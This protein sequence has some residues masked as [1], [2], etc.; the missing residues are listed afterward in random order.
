M[1][2]YQRVVHVVVVVVGQDL[3]MMVVV[4]LMAW[5]NNSLKFSIDRMKYDDENFLL[6]FVENLNDYDNQSLLLED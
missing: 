3:L 1:A 4:V 2:S 6:A 5:R